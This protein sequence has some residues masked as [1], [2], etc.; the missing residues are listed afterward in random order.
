MEIEKM[1]IEAGAT[2]VLKEYFGDGRIS[3]LSFRIGE[4]GYKLP[5]NSERVYQRLKQ[6]IYKN[7]NKAW[8]EE[9]A[10]RVAWRVLKDWLHTQL[11]LIYI[12]QAELEQVMLPYAYDGEQTI[13]EL[14]KKQ[15]YGVF[16]PKPE[17]EAK[18]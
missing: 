14:I 9:Q 3:T 6:D 18:E 15:G 2:H 12:G 8:L 7:K 10:E 16:L 11:S 1:L 4:M 5:A 17:T 13:Y